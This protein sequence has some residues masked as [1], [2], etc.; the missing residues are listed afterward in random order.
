MRVM[1][2][3]LRKCP[4][5]VD[6]ENMAMPSDLFLSLTQVEWGTQVPR[7]NGLRIQPQY[8]LKDLRGGQGKHS[9]PVR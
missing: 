6:L 8:D 3:F 1:P 4:W 7:L 5:A 2:R 9:T